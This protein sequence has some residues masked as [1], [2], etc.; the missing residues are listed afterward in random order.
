MKTKNSTYGKRVS[1]SALGMA[2]KR[3]IDKRKGDTSFHI[4]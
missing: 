3:M 2:M 1:G 4:F